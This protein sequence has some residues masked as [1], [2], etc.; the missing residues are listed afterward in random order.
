MASDEVKS[1]SADVVWFDDFSSG[2]VDRDKWNVRTTGRVVNDE[3][4][5]YVDSSE[6]VYVE[7]ETP[8]SDNHVLVLHAR[9]RPGFSAEGRRFEVVSGRLD[10]R[11]RF[12]FM[13]GSVSARIKLS[14]GPGLWPAFWVMGDGQWP[15]IG[16]IDV[17][18]SVGD[19]DWVSCAVHG[20]GYSGEAG[21]VNKLYFADGSAA[22]DWHTYSVDWAP[23][24]LTFMVDGTV[25]YRVTKPMVEFSGSWA[26]DNEKFLVLNLAVGGTYPFKTNGVREPFYG[27][28]ERALERIRTGEARVLIDWVRVVGGGDGASSTIRNEE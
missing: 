5:A 18:E 6:T 7:R 15:D 11:E 12:R 19:P 24:E 21:L 2:E 28:G 3:L 27:L 25:V 9:Y 23:D 8:G 16:E 1:G 17:M 14:A 4:Q 22:T 13:Y 10:T 26:F 20:P